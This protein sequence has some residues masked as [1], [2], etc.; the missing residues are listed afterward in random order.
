MTVDFSIEDGLDTSWDES[1]I[2]RLIASIIA[3]ELPQT[4]NWLI[5]LHFVTDER[6]RELNAEHRGLNA[7]TDVLSFPLLDAGV[8][9]FVVPP[10]E[11]V[12]LGDVV[13]SHPRAVEQAGEFGHSVDREVA[14]LVAHGVLHILGYDHEEDADLQRMR[15]KE[16]AALQPLGYTR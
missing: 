14:Y 1:R 12:H 10:G 6:I 9:P 7:R 13:I 15:E 3:R 4:T 8:T 2:T 16:E 5:N 11:P